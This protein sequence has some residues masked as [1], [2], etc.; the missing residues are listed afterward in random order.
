MMDVGFGGVI[1]KFE[2]H[3]GSKATKLLLGLIAL[4]IV[5]ACVAIIW[6]WLVSP[7]LT[8]FKSPQR[9]R[10]LIQLLYL[11][12]AIGF[13]TVLARLWARRWTREGIDARADLNSAIARNNKA[14]EDL[15][16]AAE[17]LGRTLK[18]NDTRL[19]VIDNNSTPEHLRKLAQQLEVQAKA[20]EAKREPAEAPPTLKQ[21]RRKPPA[22]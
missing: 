2:Q 12:L 6:Q 20:I 11:G 8:F 4:A 18:E 10:L 17:D 5:A 14:A 16:R 21:R 15:K 19:L 9:L 1:E 7:V 3:Y 22:E 13:G